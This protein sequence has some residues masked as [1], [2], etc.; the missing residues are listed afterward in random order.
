MKCKR[1]MQP[2]EQNLC[3]MGACPTVRH[4]LCRQQSQGFHPLPTLQLSRGRARGRCFSVYRSRL[5]CQMSQWPTEAH[6]FSGEPRNVLYTKDCVGPHLSA[7]ALGTGC[8]AVSSTSLHA[9]PCYQA[10][11]SRRLGPLLAHMLRAQC[12]A[13]TGPPACLLPHRTWGAQV[14]VSARCLALGSATLYDG[15]TQQTHAALFGER[16][17]QSR[18]AVHNL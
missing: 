10:L 16:A 8:H 11:A 5:K 7:S 13:P 17:P 12:R 4:G 1:R 9:R 14:H 3:T 15:G 2:L 6:S 18:F